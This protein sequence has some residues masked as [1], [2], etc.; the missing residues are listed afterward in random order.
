MKNLSITLNAAV[1]CCAFLAGS[2]AFAQTVITID[3]NPGSTTTHQTIQA[4][5]DAASSGDIIYVQPSGTN[6]GSVDIE[7]PLTIVGRSHSEPGKVSSLQTITINSSNITIKGISF[8]SLNNNGASSAPAPPPF[9]GLEVFECEFS[10]LTLGTTPS[11]TASTVIDDVVFRGN[12]FSSFTV[13]ADTNDV[14]VSNNIIRSSGTFYNSSSMV[15]ANNIFNTSSTSIT[16]QNVSSGVVLMYNNMFINN[17]SSDLNINFFSGP[18]NLSNNLTYNYGSGNAVFATVSGGTF[19]ENN[20][21]LDTDPQFTNVDSTIS[22]SFAGS[23]T[24]NPA[25]RLEDNLTLQA[26]SPALT[27]GGGGSQIGLY[28]NGFNYN[29]LGN[30]RDIPLLDIESNDA[31]VPAGSTINVTVTAKAN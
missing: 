18:F 16:L 1:L 14:L 2:I 19:Q 26:G 8:S 29:V 3:N 4:A 12:V 6:Y 20:T 30:P 27:G 23:S 24:Y 7:K 10:S 22:Q 13:F 25:F 5:H 11:Q 28:N 15:V 21:L 31:A 9:I 17:E